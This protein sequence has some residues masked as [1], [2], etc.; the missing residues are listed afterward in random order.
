[1]K[2]KY[3]GPKVL[4]SKHGIDFD[5]NKEDKYVYLNIAMQLL[6]ALDYEYIEDRVHTYNTDSRRLSDDEITANDKKYCPNADEFIEQAKEKAE[7]YFDD[8]LK[9]ARKNKNLND[10]ER[11][12]LT[13]NIMIMREYMIQRAANKSVYYCIIKA[14]AERLKKDNID[15]VIAPMFQKF[16]HVFH[17]VQGVLRQQKT[18]I[19]SV[20]EIYEEAGKLLVKLDVKNL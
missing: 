19:D 15:Y 14:L 10:D 17:S 8:E 12:A 5:N 9:R 1:M 20:M 6:E 4:I 3:V 13:N 16:A 7:R 11:L 18:P 2:L